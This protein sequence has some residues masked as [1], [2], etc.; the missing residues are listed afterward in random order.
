MRQ[1][2][3]TYLTNSFYESLRSEVSR[4]KLNSYICTRI[5][6]NYTAN[7]LFM[8]AFDMDN[9]ICIRKVANVHVIYNY[10][11]PYP[12]HTKPIIDII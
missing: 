6:T 3:Y 11:M 7:D 10:E 2:P 1:E 12:K 5:M 9:V 4:Y 8:Y